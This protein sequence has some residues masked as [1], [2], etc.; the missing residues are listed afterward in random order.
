MRKTQNLN[1]ELE[2]QGDQRQPAM[3]MH[4]RL[5]NT[6]EIAI[7]FIKRIINL[8]GL[9]GEH[10]RKHIINASRK[11]RKKYIKRRRSEFNFILH[12]DQMILENTGYIQHHENAYNNDRRD[13]IENASV[14]E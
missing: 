12:V 1:D 14:A 11:L 7:S 5:T 6:T 13:E 4:G 10:E 2:L 8:D 3:L 9:E